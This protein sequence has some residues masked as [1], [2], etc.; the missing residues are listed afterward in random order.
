MASLTGKP[1]LKELRDLR[2]GPDGR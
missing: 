1:G 2:R